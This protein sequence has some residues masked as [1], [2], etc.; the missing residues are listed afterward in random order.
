L[1][2]EFDIPDNEFFENAGLEYEYT[3]VGLVN[4]LDYYYTVTSFSKPD[5]VSFFP[6]QESSKSSNAKRIA[7]GTAAPET[8]GEVAVVPNPYRADISYNNYNPPWESPGQGRERWVEQDRKIQFIN[9][10]IPCEIKI[11]TL[12]GD[13]VQTIQHDDPER[14]FAN[15][16]L[17]SSIG[18]T[19]ASGIFLY[20][21]EDR[22]N[23][24][25]QV[26]KFVII[27]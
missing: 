12:A 18:Q 17:T 9:I 24:N 11:Y 27:K 23:G 25:V 2:K 6:S 14:G 15:W 21:V 13:L 19:V 1:L 3:D 7:P 22:K 20:S 26:G 8:V 5:T 4:N 10:P 16:N